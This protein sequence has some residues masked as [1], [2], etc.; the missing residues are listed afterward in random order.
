MDEVYDSDKCILCTKD[1]IDDRSH[2]LNCEFSSNKYKAML[3]NI[4]NIFKT[5][6]VVK[7]RTYGSDRLKILSSNN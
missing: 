5:Y 2:Y 1:V 3:E 6:N 7:S 4:N